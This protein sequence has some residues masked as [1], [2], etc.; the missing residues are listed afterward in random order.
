[1]PTHITITP[2]MES[3][4]RAVEKFAFTKVFEEDATQL[5][6][7]K[8]TGVIP[9]V[10]GILGPDGTDGRDGL[11]ATLGVTGS[12]KVGLPSRKQICERGLTRFQSHT[13][14]GSRSQRGLTQL[15]LDLIFNSLECHLLH[16]SV[17]LSLC[18]SLS[19]SDVSE[20]QLLP[21]NIYLDSLYGE[22]E[23]SMLSRAS[24]RAPTP[25]IMVGDEAFLPS[26]PPGYF[27][28]LL[29]RDAWGNS[30]R[31]EHRK[32]CTIPFNVSKPKISRAKM[33]NAKDGT[34]MPTSRRRPAPCIST[35]P[36]LPDVTNVELEL[37]GESDYAI[38]VSMYE[39]YND[40]I[41]DLLTPQSS[42]SGSSK[43]GQQKDR[44]RA[45]LFKST[46]K[47]PDRKVVAGLRKIICG[48]LNEALMVLE[49]GLYER[50]V[51]GTGS[52]SVSSRS[53]GFFC[54]EVKKRKHNSSRAWNGSTLTIVDLA[55]T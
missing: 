24:S 33:K 47:S 17:D 4:R 35:L 6:I 8:G 3:R 12:G 14:L 29:G 26:C 5:D 36:Q 38:V 16:P 53:H 2:P 42:T 41:Y 7:F 31:Q 10:E 23:T 25:M 49:T 51:A 20:A 13:I 11:I 40:R 19:S 52:N 48:D 21:A 55:G 1:M 32:E 34:H 27:P 50:R 15:S 9:L 54:V 37:D 45:L 18:S 44:R 28:S 30:P 43:T 22:P 39:V 46:E